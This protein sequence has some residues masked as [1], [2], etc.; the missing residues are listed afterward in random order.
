MF[1]TGKLTV[2]GNKT[3]NDSITASRKFAMVVKKCGYPEVKW[4]DYKISNMLASSYIGFRVNLEGL[5][6]EHANFS[7]YEPEI[8][9]GLVYKML[10]PK[11]TLLIFVSGKVVLMGKSI[12]GINQAFDII[13]P[14]LRKHKQK[15]VLVRSTKKRKGKKEK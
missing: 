13:I 12:E 3:E 15:G 5:A 8:F 6:I 7:N 4:T 14:I 1:S 2:L 9:P 10:D 11:V